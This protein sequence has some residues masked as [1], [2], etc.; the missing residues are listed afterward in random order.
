MHLNSLL[1]TSHNRKALKVVDLKEI[2]AKAQVSVTGKANKSDLIAKIL[3]SPEALK[4]YEEQHGSPA[5][6]NA[7]ETAPPAS[8]ATAKPASSAAVSPCQSRHTLRVNE[9]V[10]IA[11]RSRTVSIHM[12]GAFEQLLINCH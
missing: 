9:S 8:A 1:Y 4:V 11:C 2:L 10:A 3:A 5:T 6:Q 7:S 12:F